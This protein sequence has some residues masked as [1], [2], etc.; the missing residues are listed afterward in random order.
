MLHQNDQPADEPTHDIR[1]ESG[2]NLGFAFVQHWARI[3][4]DARNWMKMTALAALRMCVVAAMATTTAEH[5]H[6]R[7]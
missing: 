1:A 2:K 5:Q 4:V 6:T 7:Q 3:I